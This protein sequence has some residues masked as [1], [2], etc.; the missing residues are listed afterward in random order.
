MVRAVCI[1]NA[2]IRVQMSSRADLDIIRLSC[3][4]P[5][6]VRHLAFVAKIKLKRE[7]KLTIE[8]DA[9]YLETILSRPC[10]TRNPLFLNEVMD[11]S[12][13]QILRV[14]I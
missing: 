10:K 13:G 14:S 3:T 8:H 6:L 4:A 12:D 11:I 9:K 5:K 1:S 2:K 7:T